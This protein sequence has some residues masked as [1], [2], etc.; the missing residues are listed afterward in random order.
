[1][2]L[3]LPTPHNILGPGRVM[4]LSQ[5][6]GKRKHPRIGLRRDSCLK[7]LECPSLHP[8]ALGI[9]WG[10][11]T[12]WVL[13]LPES[14]LNPPGIFLESSPNLPESSLN[15][16][17]QPVPSHHRREKPPGLLLQ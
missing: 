4:E 15:P 12:V 7:P 1:M 3:C 16:P 9:L 5:V 2:D 10:E 13:S 6:P 8:T 11:G 14:S 17:R